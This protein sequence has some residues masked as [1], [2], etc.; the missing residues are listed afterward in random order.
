MP[1]AGITG[2]GGIA[3]LV[4]PDWYMRWLPPDSSPQ[5][6]E[7]NAKTRSRYADEVGAHWTGTSCHLRHCR[8]RHRSSSL[9]T[10]SGRRH[11]CW[12]SHV[13]A[14]R[15]CQDSRASIL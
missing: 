1:V 3:F 7:I 4:A 5:T 8:S 13:C 12:G 6:T 11:T 15:T 9:R 10:Y 2:S 14:I